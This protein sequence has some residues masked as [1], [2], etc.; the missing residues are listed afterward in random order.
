[1]SPE[2]WRLSNGWSQAFIAQALGL[3][4]RNPA[5]TWQR[6]ESGERQ[7]PLRVIRKVEVLSDGKVTMLSWIALRSTVSERAA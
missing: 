4:G 6:W 3:T 2:E 5:R 7:P 1:M